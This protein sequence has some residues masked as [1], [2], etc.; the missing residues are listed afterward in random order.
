MRQGGD[1]GGGGV[2]QK[3]KKKD[4][5]AEKNPKMSFVF[6]VLFYNRHVLVP[7]LVKSVSSKKKKIISFFLFYLTRFCRIW[8][9]KFPQTK[10]KKDYAAGKIARSR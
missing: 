3:K 10:N 6:F 2:R 7:N 5:A 9:R 4:L 8:L 1:G